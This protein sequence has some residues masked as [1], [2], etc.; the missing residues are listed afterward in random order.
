MFY[1]NFIIL[2]PSITENTIKEMTCYLYIVVFLI[3]TYIIIDRVMSFLEYMKPPPLLR[4]QLLVPPKFIIHGMTQLHHFYVKGGLYCKYNQVEI[5]VHIPN[6]YHIL[7]ISL[8]KD[9]LT[10]DIS[11][12][13]QSPYD[14]NLLQSHKFDI[15]DH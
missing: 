9:T 2:T 15:S 3:G 1:I 5:V 4:F 8:T 14:L 13:T 12:M 10:G 7:R 11:Q 6:Q